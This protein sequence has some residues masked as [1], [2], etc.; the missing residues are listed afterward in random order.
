MCKL[1]NY[2]HYLN[3]TSLFS[4]IIQYQ[5]DASGVVVRSGRISLLVLKISIRVLDAHLTTFESYVVCRCSATCFV[6]YCPTTNIVYDI[7][8]QMTMEGHDSLHAYI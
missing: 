7:S 6:K 2:E 8:P 3:T 5:K 1:W 4:L